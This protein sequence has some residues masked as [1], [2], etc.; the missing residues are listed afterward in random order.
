MPITTTETTSFKVELL[1]ATHN[2][3]ASGGDQF[4]V[5]LITNGETGTYDATSTNYSDITGNTDEVTGTGYTAGGENMTNIEPTSS[6]TTAFNDFN[7]VTWTTAT[8]STNGCM[9][10][11]STDANAAV[12]VHDF[13]GT[14]SVSAANFTLVMP[15]ADASNAIIRLA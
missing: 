6:G 9:I 2:F 4:K 10:Y 11:N 7:D 5:A 3:S 8:F 15:T 1:T 12:S 14:Q 13:G